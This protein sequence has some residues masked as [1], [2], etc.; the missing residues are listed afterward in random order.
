[1]LTENNILEILST[2]IH[3]EY[4]DNLVALE[5]IESIIINGNKLS[6]T[7]KTKKVRDPFVTSLK[8]ICEQKIE[9]SY[10]QLKSGI[11]IT[12]RE[13][14]PKPKTDKPQSTQINS[15]NSTIK[16]IIAVASGKGGVGKST[17]TANLAVTLAKAGYKVGIID[18][19]VYGPSQPKMFGCEDYSALGEKVEGKDFIIPVERHGV[20]IMSIGFFIKPTDALVWRG[21]MATNALKQIIHQ[22]LWGELD[23]LLIDLPPGTGD[24]HLTILAEMKV[25]GAIIVSTPQKVAL[26]DVVR[27]IAMFKAP[28]INVPIIGIIE[29][30]AWFTPAELPENKYYIFGKDGVKELA[31]RENIKLLAQIPLVQSICEA[32]DNG[33]PESLTNPIIKSKYQ[34][35]ITNLA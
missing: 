3:P 2:I 34:E 18:A 5:M 24:V 15:E 10:P 16:N 26:A 30:M 19:D 23:Y 9:F 20:K 33:E 13:P 25:T 28:N 4:A 8:K 22:T 1:M 11:T 14:S 17:V 27:G 7:I 35:L 32:S 6:F 31:A 12:T 21:P 29:I